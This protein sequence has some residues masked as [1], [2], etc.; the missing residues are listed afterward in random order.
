L[1]SPA[2]EQGPLWLRF[3]PAESK[4]KKCK[5]RGLTPGRMTPGLSSVNQDGTHLRLGH[6]QARFGL[7]FAPKTAYAPADTANGVRS[8]GSEFATVEFY[9]HLKRNLS[10]TCANSLLSPRFKDVSY[11]R[12]RCTILTKPIFATF[13]FLSTKKIYFT[14]SK[15]E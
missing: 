5:Y 3:T 7:H 1:D 10:K 13:F 12:K 6:A 2:T 11:L 8:G 15:L 4:G 9:C 14:L